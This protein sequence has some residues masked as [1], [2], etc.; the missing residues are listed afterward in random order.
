MFGLF[1]RSARQAAPAATRYARPSLENLE[2]RDCPSTIT[3]AVTGYFANRG[4]SCAGVLTGDA[5]N[6][7]VQL[8][9]NGQPWC[10][11]TTDA[12]GNWRTAAQ[13][14]ALGTITAQAVDGSSNVVS[15]TLAASPA[16]VIDQFLAVEGIGGWWTFSGHVKDDN[17]QGEVV[18]FTAPKM[19]FINGQ[20]TAVDS[21]GNFSITVENGSDQTGTVYLNAVNWWGLTSP[22]VSY[23]I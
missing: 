19:S 20:S 2:V 3:L 16:P 12:N 1:Q 9:I 17:Y 21:S 7:Q 22:L 14:P 23:T 11:T 5:P 13:A 4:I 8:Y 6:S 15:A 10:Y 18:R